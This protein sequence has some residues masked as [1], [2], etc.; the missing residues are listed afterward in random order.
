[1]ESSNTDAYKPEEMILRVENASI[2]KGNRDSATT[3][4]LAVLA[5]SF[6]ALGALF[7]T[8]VVHDSELSYSL[9]RLLGG[10]VFSL[11]L[12]LVIVS[13]AE[14]FTGNNLLVMAW[15]DR[16]ITLGQL[17]ANWGVVFVGNFVGALSIVF[18]VWLSGHWHINQG[19]LG[20]KVVAIAVSKAN[21]SWQDAF[22]RGV[23]C[24][25]LVCLAVWLCFACRSVTDK[26]LVI[27]FPITAFVCLGFE[28]SVANMYFLPAGMLAGAGPSISAS[29]MNLIAVTLGNIVGGG[30]CVALV[31]WFI[32]LRPRKQS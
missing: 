28:H 29:A 22:F 21:L 20:E 2:V 12:I 31:Y 14:L 25:I 27:L 15:A 1:M 7:Y 4:G 10:L 5:G 23:L 11:G 8:F 9:T 24:N 30:G 19:M 26:I 13:G 3:F 32:Y 16:K 18:L 17:L 6:I